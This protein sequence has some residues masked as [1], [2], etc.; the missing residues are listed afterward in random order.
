MAAKVQEAENKKASKARIREGVRGQWWP[1]ETTDAELRELQ[2]EGMISANLSFMHDS[3]VPKPDADERVMT[4]AWVECG[5][6]LPCSEFFLSILDTYGLQ[7]HNICPN[8][9]LLLSN[10]ATLCEGHLGIRPDLDTLAEEDLRNILSVPVSG[11]VAEEDPEDPEEEEEQAPRKAAPRPS[12]RPRARASGSDAG[13]SGEASAKKPKVTK[14]PPL[15]SKKA[16]RERLKLLATAG[17]HSRP[18]ILGATNPST[19]TARTNVQ[20]PITKYMKKFPAVGPA[21][22]A[23]PSAPQVTPQ[24]SPPQAERSPPPATATPPEIIPVSSEK[25]GRENSGGKGPAPD[26]TEAQGREEAEVNSSGKAE[27]VASEIVVFP[28]N[29]GD[30]ADLTSTPKAYATKFFNKLTEA[31][32]WEL[33]QDLLNSMLDNAWSKPDAES[34]EIQ[35]FKKEI[36][37]FLDKLLYKRKVEKIQ[38]FKQENADLK[39]KLSDAQGAST[40]LAAASSEL[41]TLR[42][43]HKDLQSKLAEAEKKLAEKSSEL[44][45]KEREFQLKRKADSETIKHQHKE[46]GGLR[47]YMEI[48]EQC[49]DLL[50]SDFMDPLGYDEERRSQFPRDDLLQLAGEDCKDLISASRKIFHNLSINKS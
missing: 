4:K 3:D 11:D 9:Y 40:S 10:F 37:Q 43:S 13:A 23:P 26:E 18:N 42:S 21:T 28:K 35:D 32:I 12:K 17:K 41:E 8:S 29:F 15:D 46:L 6:S 27:A 14:P 50:N 44:I 39:K 45:R 22:P 31:E 34:S 16:E 7:P 20:E 19:T 24:P 33:E 25:V 49:W 2:N 5:L 47:K 36:C 1:C 30:P 48:A 38:Q